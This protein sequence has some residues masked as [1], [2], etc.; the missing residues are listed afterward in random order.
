VDSR[1]HNL[2]TFTESLDLVNDLIRSG[3]VT[4]R[5][6]VGE[7]RKAKIDACVADSDAKLQTAPTDAELLAQERSPEANSLGTTVMMLYVMVN[8]KEL[9][10]RD[11]EVLINAELRKLKVID[12][13]VQLKIATSAKLQAAMTNPH[14]CARLDQQD[15]FRIKQAVREE[16]IRAEARDGQTQARAHAF[17]QNRVTADNGAVYAIIPGTAGRLEGTHAAASVCQIDVDG[18][19]CVGG[20]SWVLEVRQ[21][22]FDCKGHYADVD[23]SS[24]WQVAAPSSVARALSDLVCGIVDHCRLDRNN[25][26]R[27]D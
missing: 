20:D 14:V 7:Q 15:V 16:K 19:H 9:N 13:R 17:A 25:V 11:A 22:W 3:T 24:G 26:C 6:T 8:C 23:S 12:P 21:Y 10:E 27:M 2:D 4:G 1:K 5:E 18:K